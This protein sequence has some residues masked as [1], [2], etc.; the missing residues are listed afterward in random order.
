MHNKVSRRVIARTVAAKLLAEPANQAHWLQVTAAYLLEQHM[1]DDADLMINDIARELF[2]QSGHLLVDVTSARKLS[3]KVREE[4][5]HTMRKAT[6]AK[7]VELTEHIDANL[8]GG[9]VART[10]DAQLDASVRTKLKQLAS[11]Q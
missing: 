3:D 5:Q 8:L 11:L 4:L 2:E 1:A 9:L 6:G 10:P 7:R